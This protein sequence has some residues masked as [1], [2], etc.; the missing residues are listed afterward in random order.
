MRR[1]RLLGISKVLS[2]ER[3]DT[4]AFPHLGKPDKPF[5][6]PKQHPRDMSNWLVGYT[7][8]RRW[9]CWNVFFFL[10]PKSSHHSSSQSLDPYGLKENANVVRL[11]ASVCWASNFG[12]G[13]DLSVCGFEPC[14][15]LCADSS[16]PGACFCFYVSLS[17]CPSP[18]CTLS[19]SLSLKNR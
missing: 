17:L 10:F 5:R 7:D 2:L 16:E 6:M 3:D 19:L 11:G 14:V 4:E 8:V 12:S 9:K 13:H 1:N 18:A 15:R